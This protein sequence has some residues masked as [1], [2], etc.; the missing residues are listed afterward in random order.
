MDARSSAFPF[1]IFHP[2]TRTNALEREKQTLR[3]SFANFAAFREKKNPPAKRA[4]TRKPA[5]I[6]ANARKF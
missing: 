2:G 6:A 1:S 4:T 5:Q 3:T